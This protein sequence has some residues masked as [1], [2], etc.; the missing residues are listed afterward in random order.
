MLVVFD[1][2]NSCCNQH[3]FE[4]AGV[5]ETFHRDLEMS[6]VVSDANMIASFLMRTAVILYIG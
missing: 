6:M 5:E 1:Q 3:S 2:P 4:V